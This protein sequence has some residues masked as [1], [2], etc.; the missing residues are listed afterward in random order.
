MMVVIIIIF[1]MGRR[2]GSKDKVKREKRNQFGLTRSDL[3]NERKRQVKRAG[4]W[5]TPNQVTAATRPG[6]KNAV[7][8]SKKINGVV[9]YKL[10]NFGDSTMSDWTKHKD[11]KRRSNYLS[12]SGGIRNKSGEL[13]KNDKFSANYWSRKIN[14]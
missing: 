4:R 12:R 10:L 8:A 14:W 11:K 6:K 5:W 9:K 13:T 3:I 1:I 2:I 7:L